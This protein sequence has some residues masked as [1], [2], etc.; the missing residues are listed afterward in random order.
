MRTA[1]FGALAGLAFAIAG[2]NVA[3]AESLADLEAA[4]RAE[5]QVVSIGMP[6]DWANWREIWKAITTK[7]GVTHTDTDMSSAEQLA[8]FDAERANAS[9]E[10]GEIGL[11]FGPI[12]AK[13]G[14]SQ[15]Y[16]TTNW[17]QIP[18]WARDKDGYWAL[19][20]TGTIAFVISND[21]KN[22]PKSFAD[23]LNGDYKVNVGEVGKA[24]QA[25]AAVLAAAVAMGGGEENLQPAMDLFAKLAA[26]NRLLAINANAAL[27]EK[28][29]VQVAI[30]W[31]FNA[32]NWRDIAG[33]DKWTVV[34]P[35]D[36][37]ITSGYTTAINA[38]TKRPAIAKLVR[39]FIFSDEGQIMYARGYARPIRI[40]QITLPADVAEKVLPAE[41][42][43]KARPINVELWTD[44]AKQLTKMW[45]EQVAAQM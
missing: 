10:I 8:K 12:A 23:L 31:D 6:D 5:G 32:L 26:D 25:N 15:P 41:Q 13:K 37:S 39:E 21:V 20:Y 4:A 36:G 33:K 27:M 45:Q 19:G 16:K 24:A 42:Y 14:L 35:S 22:P 17:E 38:F 11:E 3:A 18:E 28:G 2:A 29:E 40:D 34:I 43:A 1:K 7:Y 9:T 44:A 30:V